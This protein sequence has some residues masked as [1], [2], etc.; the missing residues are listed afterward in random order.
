[1]SLLRRRMMMQTH[2]RPSLRT[3]GAGWITT[4]FLLTED[5]TVECEYADLGG[6][7]S[8]FIYS[9]LLRVEAYN[10]VVSDPR[11][12]VT[13]RGF[14][15]KPYERE[16]GEQIVVRFSIKDRT[17]CKNGGEIYK[18]YNTQEDIEPSTI[19]FFTSTAHY[20]TVDARLFYFKVYQ[21]EELIHNLV[22]HL[23]SNGIA[24]II[25]KITGTMYYNEN[26]SAS[27]EFT[28]EVV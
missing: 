5:M 11:C 14:R 27:S 24:C 10:T 6:F 12:F 23:D 8:D 28:Y 26:S 16:M 25:D 7:Y 18:Y 20:R 22:P 21:N 9:S 4:D 13:L 2:K 3:N 17:V 15:G 1:M 19:T